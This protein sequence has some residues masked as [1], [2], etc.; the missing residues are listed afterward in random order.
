MAAEKLV[1]AANDTESPRELVDLLS[2]A[3]DDIA[4]GSVPALAAQRR[5]RARIDEVFADAA[6]AVWQEPANAVAA[7][8]YVLSGGTPDILRSFAQME[9]GPAV[10]ERL[11][12]GALAY[13]EGRQGE[14]AGMLIDLEAESLPARIRGQVALAQAALLV[15]TDPK[16]ALARLDMARLVAPGTLIEEAAI[17]RSLFI[18]DQLRDE[19]RFERLARQYL[20]RFKRSIYAGNFRYR[21]AAALTHA[22]LLDDPAQFGRLDAMLSQ[23]DADAQRGLYLTVASA[24]VVAGKMEAGAY[25]AEKAMALARPE[26]PDLSRARVYRA[27]ALVVDAEGFETAEQDL[28]ATNVAML[29]PSDLALHDAVAR[30]AASIGAGSDP[31]T[32]VLEPEPQA[33]PGEEPPE[34]PDALLDRARALSD[35]VDLLLASAS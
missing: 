13:V 10:D 29:Q 18:V 26:S 8:A 14:A 30:I 25:A 4:V 11:P 27:A 20:N 17:R 21:F 7:V 28:A 35:D 1:A 31:S 15:G 32:I 23:L 16:G 12:R 24:A 34:E 19:E 9:P 33:I 6:P 3:Q 5:I 2:R 22:P